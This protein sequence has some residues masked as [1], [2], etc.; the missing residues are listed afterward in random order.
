MRKEFWK[1]DGKEDI[2]MKLEMI[3]S[4]LKRKQIALTLKKPKQKKIGTGKANY[5]VFDCF[6]FGSGSMFVVWLLLYNMN[7]ICTR[8]GCIYFGKMKF[9]SHV[10]LANKIIPE[11]FVV[12]IPLVFL[13]IHSSFKYLLNEY[14]VRKPSFP[15]NVSLKTRICRIEVSFFHNIDVNT[16]PIHMLQSL[17]TL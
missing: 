17:S 14:N 10:Y 8:W 6:H 2:G 3:P 11:H 1:W 16:S 13:P 4:T 7:L 15:L 9:T 12:I 5:Q